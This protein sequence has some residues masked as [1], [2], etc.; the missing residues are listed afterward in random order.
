M[1]K[2]PSNIYEAMKHVRTEIAKIKSQGEFAKTLGVDQS[3]ISRIESGKGSVSLSLAKKVFTIYKYDL[4]RN[5]MVAESRIP[6][7]SNPRRGPRKPVKKTTRRT[8][9]K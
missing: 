2:Q 9:K 6:K 8:T 3:T 1:S 5:E 7:K 4:I